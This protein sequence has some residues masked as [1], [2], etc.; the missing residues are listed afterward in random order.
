MTTTDIHALLDACEIS[1]QTYDDLDE[2]GQLEIQRAGR[3]R[4]AV[5]AALGVNRLAAT[6][7]QDPTIR[8]ET[9]GYNTALDHV[10]HAITAALTDDTP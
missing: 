8:A 3:M 6:D 5:E 1:E 7:S 10:R 9:A 2:D 4:R